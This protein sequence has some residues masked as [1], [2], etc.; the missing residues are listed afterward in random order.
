MSHATVRSETTSCGERIE[1][2]Q[3]DVGW[4]ALDRAAGQTDPTQH[5]RVS[6]DG[7][8]ITSANKVEFSKFEVIAGRVERDGQHGRRFVRAMQHRSL[9]RV[10]I[11]AALAQIGMTRRTEVDVVN[12]GARGIRSLVAD[13]APRMSPRFIDW[14]HVAMKLQAV[15]TPIAARKGIWT[16]IPSP[17]VR[18]ERL[19]TKVRDALWR[20]KGEAAIAML[21]T[22]QAA[23]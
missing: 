2:E 17:I 1:D 14:F 10:L 20:G 7:T 22:L 19:A 9:T 12:D 21:D 4:F 18:A 3:F 11:A 6:I 5:L 16:P 8:V 23:L 15:R 13:V